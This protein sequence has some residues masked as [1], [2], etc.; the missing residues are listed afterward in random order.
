ML[1][2]FQREIIALLLLAAVAFI[3]HQRPGGNIVQTASIPNLASY[4]ESYISAL[5]SENQRLRELLALKRREGAKIAAVGEVA[6]VDSIGW[7]VWITAAVG[8]GKTVAPNLMVLDKDGNL[9]GRVCEQKDGLVKIMTILNPQSRISVRLR[10]SGTLG[11]LESSAPLTLRVGYIPLGYP[12]K[13]GD[14]VVTSR[15]SQHYPADIPVGTVKKT[16]SGKGFFLEVGI[17]PK[18]DFSA[19]HEVVIVY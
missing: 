2:K 6:E 18:A 3:F 16:E 5:I 17:L 4:R 13:A 10:E 8:D 9:V 11:V 7:P 15:I 14:T 12:V 1:W 19:L